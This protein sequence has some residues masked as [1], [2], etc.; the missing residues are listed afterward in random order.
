MYRCTCAYKHLLKTTDDFQ[1]M[2][3]PPSSKDATTIWNLC[4]DY[5]YNRPVIRAAK[6]CPRPEKLFRIPF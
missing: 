4:G 5:A 3:I 1:R 2:N 6:A